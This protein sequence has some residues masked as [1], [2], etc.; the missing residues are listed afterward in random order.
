MPFME[1]SRMESRQEFVTLAQQDGANIRGLCRRFGISPTT[2]YRWLGRAAAGDSLTD[3]SRRPHHQPRRTDPAI[4]AAVVALRHQHPTWGG[5]T[6]KVV[7]ERT[8]ERAPAAAT[9]TDIL[10]RHGLLDPAR[11][12]PQAT[13]TFCAAAPNA[14]WQMD[15]MGHHPL[16]QGRVHPFTVLDDHSRYALALEAC[17]NQQRATVELL[18]TAVFRRFGLPEVILCDNGPPWG[19]AGQG[20][21]TALEAWLLQLGIDVWHGR[22]RHPQTQG[23]IER[24]HR[25]VGHACFPA[26]R[27]P[28]ATLAEAATTFAA[29]R[30]TYNHDRPHHALDMAVPASRYTMS[31]RAF[32]EILPPLVYDE[33]DEIRRV[34]AQ[35]AISYHRRIIFVSRGLIGQPVAVRPTTTDGVIEV[36]FAHRLLQTIDLRHPPPP[37]AD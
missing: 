19:T 33:G 23:K 11:S 13:R 7:L 26:T 29:M 22:P 1:V 4:E 31:V 28:M 16:R 32:P 35:G 20:G 5:R 3:R 15:F 8:M 37:M 10:R 36:R 30:Q 12:H 24:F 6:L 34:R 2:G 25:T 9:I 21:I 14:L 17:A 27:P 18:L